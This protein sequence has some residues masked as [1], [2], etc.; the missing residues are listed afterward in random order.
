LITTEPIDTVALDGFALN[1]QK[2]PEGFAYSRISLPL[3][4][5]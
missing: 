1:L 4:S 5:S 2:L 3:H